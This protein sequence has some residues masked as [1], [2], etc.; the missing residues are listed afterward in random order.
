MIN[1]HNLAVKECFRY[2]PKKKTYLLIKC[3]PNSYA[4]GTRSNALYTTSDEI[5]IWIAKHTN[6]IKTRYHTND[7]FF[8]VIINFIEYKSMP[9][10]VLCFRAR[11][12][13]VSGIHTHPR[14]PYMPSPPPAYLQY[15]HPPNELY[16]MTVG[17][18]KYYI[19]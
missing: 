5:E 4:F 10:T 18:G 1:G 11:P 6:C 17:L 12:P 2:L 8:N 16:P 19:M 3:I 9:Q 13:R 7:I 15:F 14:E